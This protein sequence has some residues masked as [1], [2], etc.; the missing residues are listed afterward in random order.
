MKTIA[1]IPARYASTRMPGKPLA[2][3]LLLPLLLPARGTRPPGSIDL[4]VLD[5]GQ[6]LSV[7]VQSANH[8]LLYDAGPAFPGG[9]DMG[10]AAVVPA[11]RALGVSGLDLFLVSHGEPA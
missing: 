5:V 7:L 11:L 10:E 2:L 4:T 1:V 6:G 8:T 3:L 9:L